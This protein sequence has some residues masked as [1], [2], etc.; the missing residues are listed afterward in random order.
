MY[1]ISIYGIDD[2]GLE[3]FNTAHI[4]LVVRLL[5]YWVGFLFSQ[6]YSVILNTN[7]MF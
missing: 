4:L 3:V 5:V 1:F 7:Q 6:R 2:F